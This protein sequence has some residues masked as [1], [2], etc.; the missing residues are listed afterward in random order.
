M[1]ATAQTAVV[2]T[3]TVEARGDYQRD[4]VDGNIRESQSGF[5][6]RFFNLVLDGHL[7]DRIGYHL[8]QRFNRGITNE[9]F[10][11]ATDWFYI[12]Y[13]PTAAWTFTAGKQAIDVGGWE[14]DYPPINLYFCSEFWNQTPCYAW[15]VSAAYRVSPADQLRLQVCESPNRQFAAN[16]HRDLYAYNLMWYGQHGPWGTKWSVN[17]VEWQKGH[18][19]SYIA[20]GN[21]LRFSRMV[22]LELDYMNRA[23]SHQ[24]F[25]LRD[26][27]VIG[28]LNYQPSSRLKLF[29]K[30]SYDV[31][32]T[33]SPADQILQ[34]GTELTRVGAGAEFFPLGDNR[35]RLHAN[36]CYSWGTNSSPTAV[37]L[38]K[39]Q[40]VDVGVTW[41]LK[42]KQ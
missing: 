5:K 29:A 11:N 28:Q 17:M 21:E 18:Y 38:D 22:S 24:A 40:L 14:Y 23:A 1:A 15:G 34:A 2:E 12:D 32:R 39:Q 42:L 41:R 31:N 7:T 16:A 30:A 13:K 26:C 10:F 27:S 35:L 36:Y 20:L 25:L 3:M 8:R 33:D 6:G 9:N 4:Y 19:I 37:M